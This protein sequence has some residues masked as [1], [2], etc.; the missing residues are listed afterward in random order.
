MSR[1]RGVPVQLLEERADA[2][3]EKLDLVESVMDGTHVS[4]V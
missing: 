4:E 2:L 3:I 1:L